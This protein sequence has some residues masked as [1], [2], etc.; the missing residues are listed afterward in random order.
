MSRSMG[1]SKSNG[2]KTQPHLPLLTMAVTVLHPQGWQD[3]LDQFSSVTQ[4]CPTFCDPMGCSTPG[5]P[6]HHQLLEFAQIHVHRVGDADAH[7]PKPGT[8]ALRIIP[9]RIISVGFQVSTQPNPLPYKRLKW[10]CLGN[11]DNLDSFL[12]DSLHGP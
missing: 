7:F 11:S 8:Q 10:A 5:F 12:A 2:G 9:V 6:V 4:L 3:S 1:S